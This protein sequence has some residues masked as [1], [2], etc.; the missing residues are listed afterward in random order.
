MWSSYEHNL[1]MFSFNE[2][3]CEH[4]L[5]YHL[6]TYQNVSLAKLSLNLDFLL[7]KWD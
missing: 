2:E 5:C 3:S 6:S 1:V 7:Y 4:A